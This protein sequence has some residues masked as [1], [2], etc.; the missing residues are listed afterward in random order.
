MSG[1]EKHPLPWRYHSP[2]GDV[3]YILSARDTIVCRSIERPSKEDIEAFKMIAEM[4]VLK[5]H[6]IPEEDRR[7]SYIPEWNPQ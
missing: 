1:T 6:P 3:K 2:K 5:K 4:A 7:K